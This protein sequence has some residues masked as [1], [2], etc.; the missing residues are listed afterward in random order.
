MRLLLDQ[1]LSVRLVNRLAKDFPGITHVAEVG[2]EKASD[3]AV[4]VYAK[5][6]QHLIVTKDAD[7]AELE[8]LQGWPP[9]VLWLRIGNCTTARIEELLREHAGDLSDFV[10]NPGAGVMVLG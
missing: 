1:N 5:E 2:L 8:V 9:K 7:F 6:H 3:E 4:W 10:N